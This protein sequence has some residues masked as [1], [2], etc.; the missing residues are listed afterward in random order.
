MT[1]P[2]GVGTAGAARGETIGRGINPKRPPWRG[3]WGPL[4]NR[5]T[6]MRGS[7]WLSVPGHL[8]RARR[9]PRP[10]ALRSVHYAATSRHDAPLHTPP[11]GATVDGRADTV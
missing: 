4:R 1:D 7:G 10:G 9:R 5:G 8:D 11:S 3:I 6:M 2:D